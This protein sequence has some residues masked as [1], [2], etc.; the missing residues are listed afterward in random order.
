MTTQENAHPRIVPREDWLDERK[1]LLGQE[2]ELTMHR[3]HVNAERR[4]LPMVRIDKQ[5][6]F[7]G[8]EGK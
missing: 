5:Y 4:R 1:K 6:A 7:D 2:K 3:D 8:P